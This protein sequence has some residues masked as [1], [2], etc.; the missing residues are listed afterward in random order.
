MFGYS[1]RLKQHQDQQYPTILLGRPILGGGYE[2]QNSSLINSDIHSRERSTQPWEEVLQ[3]C[4]RNPNKDQEQDH[5]AE[6]GSPIL[7][8]AFE[9]SEGLAASQTS[10]INDAYLPSLKKVNSSALNH[11]QLPCTFSV[12]NI[13]EDLFPMRTHPTHS[14]PTNWNRDVIQHP[15]GTAAFVDVALRNIRYKTELC[16]HYKKRGYCSMGIYCHFAHGIGPTLQ[17]LRWRQRHLQHEGAQH[18]D[19]ACFAVL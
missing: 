3:V 12:L 2:D 18:L 6:M 7:G 17:Q 8:G 5:L 9:G 15:N 13:P 14:N 10:Q 19:D 4:D 11:S 16:K 1:A